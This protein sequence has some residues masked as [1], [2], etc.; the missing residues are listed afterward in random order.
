[1]TSSYIRIQHGFW[2]TWSF[3]PRAKEIH[4]LGPKPLQEREMSVVNFEKIPSGFLLNNPDVSGSVVREIPSNWAPQKYQK[5]P[6]SIMSLISEELEP[7][8]KSAP[9]FFSDSIPIENHCGRIEW[10]A[11]WISSVGF[12]SF[13]DCQEKRRK[14]NEIIPIIG[15]VPKK[16]STGCGTCWNFPA[17]GEPPPMALRFQQSVF[18]G[19]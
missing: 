7:E 9:S 5:Y 4:K 6:C 19:V 12:F 18:I 10:L 16:T 2:Q 11:K 14:K 8:E 17:S 13:S 3:L 15:R 1:M